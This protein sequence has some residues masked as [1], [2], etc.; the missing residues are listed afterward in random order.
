MIVIKTTIPNPIANPDDLIAHGTANKEDPIIVFQIAMLEKKC[1]FSRSV[2][3]K[4]M[5]LHGD[6]TRLCSSLLFFLPRKM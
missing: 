5:D 3:K 6:H 2:L 1:K 4:L